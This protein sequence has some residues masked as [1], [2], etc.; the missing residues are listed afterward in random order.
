MTCAKPVGKGRVHALDAAVRDKL[1]EPLDAADAR[2]VAARIAT[3]VEK[4]G[5][6]QIVRSVMDAFGKEAVDLVYRSKTSGVLGAFRVSAD[7]CVCVGCGAAVP[8]SLL[9]MEAHVKDGKPT[10]KE[11]E[12]FAFRVS[13][14]TYVSVA[15]VAEACRRAPTADDDQTSHDVVQETSLPTDAAEAE[16]ATRSREAQTQ[17]QTQNDQEDRTETTAAD[18]LDACAKHAA[19]MH[20]LGRPEYGLDVLEAARDVVRRDPRDA[21]V[22]VDMLR[23]SL[24][25]FDDTDVL[26]KVQTVLEPE[27][28][29]SVT[30]AAC[31]A[32]AS[33]ALAKAPRDVLRAVA[34]ARPPLRRADKADVM[35]TTAEVARRAAELFR[36]HASGRNNKRKRYADDEAEIVRALAKAVRDAAAA[37][38]GAQDD[39]KAR[40]GIVEAL[41]DVVRASEARAGN[42][43]KRE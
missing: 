30:G 14:K 4:K 28:A 11:V 16:A 25:P 22:V 29:G 31:R 40:T 34:A 37:L 17:T 12:R 24:R 20:R 42:S 6:L 27:A 18:L 5:G 2:D 9:K 35:R 1:L 23:R 36:D 41:V 10:R 19:V 7:A 15:D 38:R 13:S 33:G 39:E 32:V 3:N 8:R 21:P 26:D 43:S